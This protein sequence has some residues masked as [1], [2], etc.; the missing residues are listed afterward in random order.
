MAE[1]GVFEKLW[2]IRAVRRAVIE[3][4]NVRIKRDDD[5][6]NKSEK[7]VQEIF[8]QPW[9]KNL[10]GVYPV[11]N[12]YIRAATDLQVSY[13]SLVKEMQ[14]YLKDI[15]TWVSKI[16][17]TSEQVATLEQLNSDLSVR[18]KET[19]EELQAERKKSKKKQT[20][21]PENATKEKKE[22]KAEEED[23]EQWKYSGE[24]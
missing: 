20:K 18:L 12:D 22:D 3:S 8:K 13:L 7:A 14:A 2:Q 23:E 10:G 21:T 17:Q 4:L 24:E 1:E 19:E 5:V 11:V 16:E 9:F 6:V 15:N